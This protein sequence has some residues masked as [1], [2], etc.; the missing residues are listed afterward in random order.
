MTDS[1][2]PIL[3][4]G[5]SD[6]RHGLGAKSAMSGDLDEDLVRL[7][8]PDLSGDSTSSGVFIGH[9][10]EV[11]AQPRDT[12]PVLGF[13]GV[14]AGAEKP[15]TST[16]A[17][18]QIPDQ[19]IDQLRAQMTRLASQPKTSTN[20]LWSMFLTQNELRDRKHRLQLQQELLWRQQERIY[21]DH[22]RD[23]MWQNL[24]TQKD[25]TEALQKEADDKEAN[26]H[27]E[28]R[29]EKLDR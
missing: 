4:A 21:R 18:A 22:Q 3:T 6:R 5:R 9:K 17:H 24:L 28:K 27:A 8:T 15:T 23:V 7:V 26:R 16:S 12:D 20:H 10:S 1:D 25:H 13:D 14:Y 2:T 19:I 11:H 29:E